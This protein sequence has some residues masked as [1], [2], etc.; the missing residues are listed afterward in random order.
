[1]VT[2]KSV[3]IYKD[4]LPAM[5]VQK[6]SSQTLKL[7][8]RQGAGGHMGRTVVWIFFFLAAVSPSFIFEIDPGCGVTTSGVGATREHKRF[9]DRPLF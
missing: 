4:Y 2:S 7:C 8:L 5:K 3:Y 1:M 6:L 9:C